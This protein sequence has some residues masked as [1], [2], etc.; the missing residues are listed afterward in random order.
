MKV[1]FYGN[2]LNQ[3]YFF[4]RLFRQHGWHARLICPEYQY[5]QEYHDW[6]TDDPLCDDWVYR[7]PNVRI[8]RLGKMVSV[9]AVRRLYEE[10]RAYD[11]V[12]LAEDGPALFSELTAGP[13]KICVSLGSDLVHYPFYSSHYLSVRGAFRFYRQKVKAALHGDAGAAYAMLRSFDRCPR[14][15]PRKAMIQRRQRQGLKQCVRIVCGPHLTH[16]LD[17]IGMECDKACFLPLPMDTRVLAEFDEALAARLRG[18]YADRE[19]LFLHP[20]RHYYLKADNDIYLKDNDKLLTAFAQFVTEVDKPVQLLL[21]HKGRSEDLRHSERLVGRLGIEQQV[22]WLPEMP[23]KELRAYYQL[24]QVVVCD[25]FN[26]HLPVL[27]NIGREASYF[28]RPLITAF[29]PCNQLRYGT[30]LPEHVLPAET[31]E[32]VLDAMRNLAAIDPKQRDRLGRAG[33]AWFSR[34]H[35]EQNVLGK[36]TSMIESCVR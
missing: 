27:G 1:A 3:G 8:G 13:A 35:A 20:T 2:N 34:N 26:P 5:R 31:T 4:V 18:R 36:W 15:I 9:P 21:V 10:F 22:E 17:E 6:W 33:T 28:G 25:Q 24:P 7:L 14:E 30:D 19:L 32:Q 16:L 11:A 23:N 12:L 29:G